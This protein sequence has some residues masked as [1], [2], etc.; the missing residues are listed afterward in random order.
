MTTLVGK[1]F[2]QL[3]FCIA[4]VNKNTIGSFFRVK[5]EIPTDMKSNI[6]Y[7][8]SCAQCASGTYIG[9]TIRSTY[10]RIS[11]HRGVSYRTGKILSSPSLSAI[12]DHADSTSHIIQDENF[13]ILGCENDEDGLRMLESL[14]IGKIKPKL[15]N[16]KSCYPLQVAQ[17]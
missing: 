5:D 6:V 13:K 10:M 12:R 9:S 17:F 15:N 4:L 8:Y 2:P 16:T 14:F 1:Y 3:N 11:E 7:Q